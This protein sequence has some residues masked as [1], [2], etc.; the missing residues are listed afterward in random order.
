MLL[1]FNS[2]NPRKM[3]HVVNS[4]FS[5][6]NWGTRRYLPLQK[7]IQHEVNV[8][9]N[10]ETIIYYELYRVFRQNCV[11]FIIQCN[12]SLAYISLQE[13]FKALNLMHSNRVKK[14]RELMKTD[15]WS[16]IENRHFV[17]YV[18]YKPKNRNYAQILVKPTYI[19]LFQIKS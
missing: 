17:Y 11:F 8:W 3:T 16:Q 10:V 4:F 5:W 18:L 14:P 9:K 6:K 13:I 2:T 7:K 12:P 1:N 15:S 19:I